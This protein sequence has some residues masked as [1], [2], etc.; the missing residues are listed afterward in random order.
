MGEFFTTPTGLF[1]LAILLFATFGGIAWAYLTSGE[2]E[3][4]AQDRLRDLGGDAA[5]GGTMMGRRDESVDRIAAR[6]SALASPTDEAEVS[7]LRLKMI[8]AGYKNR[9]ALEMYNASR[10]IAG[11]AVPTLLLPFLA[12]TMIKTLC[13]AIVLAALGYFIPSLLLD[14][15]IT[16]RQKALMAAFPD[17]LDL[18]VSSVEAGLGLDASFRR[19]SEEIEGAAPEL[20]GEFQLVNAEISAGMTRLEALKHLSQRTGLD[21]IQALVN[22][23]TQAERF[24]TSV[25]RSL[26]IHSSITRAKRMARAEEEAA[27]VSPKL[28]VVMILFLMPTLMIVLLGPAAVNIKNNLM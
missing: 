15:Q 10:I 20:A 13:F 4:S 2:P 14:S 3:T 22:M 25:A 27:K 23:L 8:Q 7:K 28:T 19:I 11:I 1:F 5:I 9:R 26:R 12:S 17:A 21:E 24:G 18:L 6:L 16:T